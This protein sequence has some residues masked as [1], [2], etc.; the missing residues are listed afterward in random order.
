MI[1][2]SF[3]LN[4]LI[5][6]FLINLFRKKSVG[7]YIR[8]EGPD[9]H[10][11]KEGTPTMGG[12]LFVLIGLLFGVLS[13][14]NGV[15]LTGAFLFFLIGFLDD[16]LSIA[17]KNS[18]GLRAYQKALL[19]IAA[20]SVVIAF[21]QPETAVDF[22]G[23][24]LEMGAWYYLLA[25][26]V[27]VGSSN[28][29]NLTDGLDGLA[30]WVYIS[31]A[32]P[33]WFFLKEKGF[34]ENIII[35]LSAGVLAFLIF[36]SKPARI[37]MGDTGSIALGGTLGVVSVLTK[38]EFYLI[39]FFPILVVETLSVIL[40]ILSFKLFKRRIFRM[41]PLHHHFELLSWEEEKIVAVFTIFNLI[42][43]LIA[44]EVFGVIG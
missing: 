42:S 35:L 10:G 31:G 14:E 28:A 16:F 5:Y 25:L 13:K 34:S 15:I 18:T 9:L 6:P 3:L 43:S 11:Y 1:A 36:N 37:F 30:G 41:A 7:Q 27:I 23:I 20:A 44:L 32:I 33:Y 26:I 4:L 29:M 24:K 22:F 8:K 40:Q 2:A 39:V 12:I 21:S 17:K 38:T 19:Q